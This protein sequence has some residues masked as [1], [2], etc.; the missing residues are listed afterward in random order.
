MASDFISMLFQWMTNRRGKASFLRKHL[1]SLLTDSLLFEQSRGKMSGMLMAHVLRYQI[2]ARKA[3]SPR[4][5]PI[6]WRG[7]EIYRRDHRFER[8]ATAWPPLGASL[9]SKLANNFD[10]ST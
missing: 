7:N 6:D 9:H 3:E 8:P 5:S 10:S 4:S 2:D 1:F